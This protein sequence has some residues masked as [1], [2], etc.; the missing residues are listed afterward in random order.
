[1]ESV[2]PPPGGIGDQRLQQAGAEASATVRGC[3]REVDDRI[4]PAREDIQPP[5]RLAVD[6]DH[7]ERGAVVVRLELVRDERGLLL[8]SPRDF[9]LAKVKRRDLLRA[10]M[11]TPMETSGQV[12]P[13]SL[14]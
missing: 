2:R 11:D 5:G 13:R 7:V 14:P 3:E 12:E 1:M 4:S 9:I 8:A 10:R 6:L